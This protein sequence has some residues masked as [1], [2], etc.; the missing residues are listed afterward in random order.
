MITTTIN[1]N[2]LNRGLKKDR[3]FVPPKRTSYSGSKLSSL[4]D[5]ESTYSKCVKPVLRKGKPLNL[6]LKSL[7]KGKNLI[8]DVE[9]Y[10]TKKVSKYVLEEDAFTDELLITNIGGTTVKEPI[11][12]SGKR[13]DMNGVSLQKGNNLK[14]RG[15][16]LSDGVSLKLVV[17]L[18]RGKDLTKNSIIAKYKEMVLSKKS[19]LKNVVGLKQKDLANDLICTNKDNYS[20]ISTK[21]I[22]VENT[23]YES[24]RDTIITSDNSNK[25]EKVSR[26]EEQKREDNRLFKDEEEAVENKKV[27]DDVVYKQGM[28]LYDFLK[29]NPKKRTE[30]V[31]LNYFNASDLKALID[32]G[33]VLKKRGKLII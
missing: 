30:E 13:L 16:D 8:V 31:I 2:N 14:V 27:D 20:D 3:G 5:V 23:L 19:A 32:S 15:L 18:Q 1:V 26:I 28:S 10:G 25:I 24:I 9:C 6:S 21:D 22:I 29:E 12:V 17:G 7:H 4:R 11:L 33:K